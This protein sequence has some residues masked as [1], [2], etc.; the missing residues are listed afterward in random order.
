MAFKNSLQH[1]VRG[2]TRAARTEPNVRWQLLATFL[3]VALGLIVRL[4]RG[5]WL[6]ITLVTGLVLAMEL[7][8]TALEKTLDIIKPRF[9]EQIGRVKDIMAGAVLIVSLVALASGILVFWP[10]LF[11]V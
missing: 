11:Q 10:H 2:L 3:A 1:A 7:V 5:E 8:N 4:S 6:V 9:D